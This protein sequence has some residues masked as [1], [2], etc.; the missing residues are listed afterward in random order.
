MIF[1]VFSLAA[2]AGDTVNSD[3]TLHAKWRPDLSLTASP[4]SCS[5]YVGGRITI[6]PNIAGGEWDLDDSFL[7][8]NGNEF[9]GLKAGTTRVTYA[10][11]GQSA[12]VDVVISEAALPATGQDFTPAL[13]LLG[14]ALCAGGAALAFWVVTRRKARP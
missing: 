12:Y 14:L 4:A 1:F 3:V 13:W 2:I 7:H 9:T 11:G 10:V 5:I 6:T 8:R